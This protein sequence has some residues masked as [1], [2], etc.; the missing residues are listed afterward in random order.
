M[1]EDEAQDSLPAVDS[2]PFQTRRLQRKDLPDRFWP[3]SGSHRYTVC[4]TC[5]VGHLGG[6][7]VERQSVC[8]P[9]G[10]P[11]SW[12]RVVHGA[13]G[14]EPVPPPAYVSASLSP[15]VSHTYI[16]TYMHERMNE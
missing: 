10:D 7:A 9:G 15:S 3:A 8:G 13:P 2:L 5:V 1:R 14:R 16:H 12:D 6:S 11:G 4:G